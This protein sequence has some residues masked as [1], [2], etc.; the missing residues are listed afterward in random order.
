VFVAGVSAG[1]LPD[2][3]DVLKD[4]AGVAQV[5]LPNFRPAGA[6]VTWG[7]LHGDGMQYVFPMIAPAALDGNGQARWSF[8]TIPDGVPPGGEEVEAVM[9]QDVQVHR[10][11][12]EDARSSIADRLHGGLPDLIAGLVGQLFAPFLNAV[13]QRLDALLVARGQGAAFI[14]YHEP[15]APTPSPSATPSATPQATSVRLPDACSLF[16]HAEAEA[17]AGVPLRPAGAESVTFP[18]LGPG[19]A[20]ILELANDPVDWHRA[21]L[22]LDVVDLG[23]NGASSFT[24]YRETLPSVTSQVPGLGDD[25]FYFAAESISMVVRKGN[26]AISFLIAFRSLEDGTAFARLV[27][28]RL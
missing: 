20:C 18:G 12:I 6:P 15:P 3:P 14:V 4:C 21:G 19:N 5:A 27:L 28:G 24:A 16:T 1:D 9:F 26:V 25:N 2:W 13:A 10:P 11:E 22:R 23:K 7:P 17:A 8:G